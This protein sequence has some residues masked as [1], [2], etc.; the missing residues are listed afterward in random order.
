M[1][2]LALS[3]THTNIPIVHN[4]MAKRQNEDASHRH[5]CHC[6]GVSLSLSLT[7]TNIPIVHTGMLKRQSGDTSHRRVCHCYGVSFSLTHKRTQ[8]FQSYI[9]GWRKDK[10]K[11]HPTAMYT[12]TIPSV[13][14]FSLSLSRLIP[15]TP[16]LHDGMAK[17]RSEDASHCHVCRGYR[18]TYCWPYSA[19][20]P[21][22]YMSDMTQH[23]AFIF[24]CD[25]SDMPQ[26]DAFIFVCDMPNSYVE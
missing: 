2:S 11:T 25:M 19:S 20:L 5:V 12:A 10:V 13:S 15:H 22:Y 26:H 8:T 16:K 7:Y 14:L 21:P 18:V 23:D 1:A 4:G 9:M 6:Y 24:V 3:L 17:R